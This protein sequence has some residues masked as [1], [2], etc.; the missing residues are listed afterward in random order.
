MDDFYMRMMNF[1][2]EDMQLIRPK[3]PKQETLE[4]CP[5]YLEQRCRYGDKCWLY[6]P[7]QEKTEIPG[8][9]ECGICLLKVRENN[10][11]YGLLM[12]CTHSFCLNCI[13]EWR[14]QLNIPKEVSRSCPICRTPSFY[15][16]PSAFFAENYQEKVAL[17]DDYKKRMSA[18]P[19]KYFNYGEGT[20]PF[21]SSCFYDHRYKNGEKWVPP[22]PLFEVNERGEWSVSKNPKL[23]DLL[24][25]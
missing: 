1:T 5:Y 11:E 17:A 18:V 21:S 6:H 10:R 15:V 13:K 7:P 14:G 4:V 12:G 8:D 9:K 20:C 23:S 19:C 3:P 24:G 22:P 2:Q 16:I 25:L